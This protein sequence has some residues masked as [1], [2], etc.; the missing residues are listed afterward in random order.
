MNIKYKAFKNVEETLQAIGAKA[1][2]EHL[3]RELLDFY[4]AYFTHKQQTPYIII[5]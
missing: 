1:N 5:R 3:M 4:N 2:A